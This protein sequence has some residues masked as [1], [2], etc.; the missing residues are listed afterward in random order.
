MR[1]PRTWLSFFFFFNHCESISFGFGIWIWSG[2]RKCLYIF[3][4]FLFLLN[5]GKLILKSKR[6]QS[7]CLVSKAA[8]SLMCGTF[9]FPLIWF[10][11]DSG[12]VFF[13]SLFNVFYLPRDLLSLCFNLS[14]NLGGLKLV[15]TWG[16]RLGGLSCNSL[17]TQAWR[18]QALMSQIP[19]L[20]SSK[21]KY[22]MDRLW[23]WWA[24]KVIA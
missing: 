15:L 4:F 3:F 14:A 7:H 5:L 23:V 10:G 16:F 21:G 6:T 1:I 17:S 13:P 19:Y 2:T 12:I 9:P 18:V 11:W 24:T 22:K 8:V 20:V